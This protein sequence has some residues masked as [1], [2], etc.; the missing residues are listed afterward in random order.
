MA[1]GESSMGRAPVVMAEARSRS[2]V[3]SNSGLPMR[4]LT[5]ATRRRSRVEVRTPPSEAMT[6]MESSSE[7]L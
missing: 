2:W 5:S 4:M 3:L 6:T 1:S 7:M